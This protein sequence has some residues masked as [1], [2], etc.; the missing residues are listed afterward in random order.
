MCG[1]LALWVG[2]PRSGL[3][4]QPCNVPLEPSAEPGEALLGLLGL[5]GESV[6]DFLRAFLARVFKSAC[7]ARSF[8]RSFRWD[9]GRRSRAGSCAS[10]VAS[11]RASVTDSTF[12]A[13]FWA[14]AIN[15]EARASA[16]PLTPTSCS[17]VAAAMDS[18][19][20]KPAATKVCAVAGPIPV[21]DS[22]SYD[23]MQPHRHEAP[24]H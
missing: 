2:S 22:R 10:P 19:S 17:T 1:N 5:P 14:S 3:R 6:F 15:A 12:P 24:P 20:T 18:R 13:A 4:T 8:L 11:V 16:K 7:R 23:V 21:S 9:F